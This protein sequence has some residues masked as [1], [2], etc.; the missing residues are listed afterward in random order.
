MFY[1]A[2][3]SATSVV[4]KRLHHTNTAPAVH[5]QL[6]V[7]LRES[8]QPVAVVTSF[9]PTEHPSS[10]HSR[11]HGATLSSFSSIAME[12]HPL[13]AFS[14]RIPSRMA[15]SLKNTHGDASSNLV[16]NI[17]S[18]NQANVAVQ[19]SRPDLHP[20]PFTSIPHTLTEEGLPVIQDSL[21]ALS[22]RLVAT[23]WPLH[24]LGVLKT[25]QRDDDS[26]WQGDGIASELFIAE[27]TRVEFVN[28]VE[29]DGDSMR[30]LPL[31]YHRQAYATTQSLAPV[32]DS[33][34]GRKQR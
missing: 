25:G 29:G 33:D 27:V 21:G 20:Y 8:A 30:T 13:V 3:R 12:P 24:D 5:A 17:L 7:L 11:F 26:V 9:M 2:C 31:L 34:P 6:R 18:A 16:V 1:R 14:L 19:F 4:P 23:S 22:C 28:T 32:R 15:T 10:A